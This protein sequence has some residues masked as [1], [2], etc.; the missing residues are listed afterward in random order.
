MVFWNASLHI[1]L[2]VSYCLYNQTQSQFAPQIFYK[3]V[4]RFAVMLVI[5]IKDIEH[6]YHTA[7][8]CS[9]HLEGASRQLFHLHLVNFVNF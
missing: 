8:F 1:L 6:T 3:G 4:V 2:A 7:F 9:Q 5:L